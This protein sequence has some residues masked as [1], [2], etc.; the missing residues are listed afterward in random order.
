M[1]YGPCVRPKNS[2]TKYSSFELVYG[3][4][5][6]QPFEL[7]TTF[8]NSNVQRSEEELLIEK[9]IDHYKWVIDACNSIKKNNKYWETR[10][11]EITSLN[12]Q[13]EIKPGDLVKI[14]NFTRYKLDPYFV[15][16]FEVESKQF[17]T[18]KLID[19]NT[20]LPLERPVHLKNIIKF[21]STTIP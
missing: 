16:P 5:D 20:K 19:P 14:R 17:N 15:G 9:F 12:K 6:Q 13:N 1:L 10:R 7:S 2:V 3:R 4:Q 18:T 8:P 21:N 11:E